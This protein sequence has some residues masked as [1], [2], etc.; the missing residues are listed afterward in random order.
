M[1][2]DRATKP[3]NKQAI[4]AVRRHIDEI[5]S[6]VNDYRFS[7]ISHSISFTQ[8]IPGDEL[9]FYMAKILTLRA[10]KTVSNF[11]LLANQTEGS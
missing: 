8:G 10:V 1:L 4:K 11:G 9:V 7:M 3:K 6:G 2:L 5:V